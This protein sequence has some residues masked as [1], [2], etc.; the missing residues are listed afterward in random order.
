MSTGTDT[1]VPSAGWFAGR[2]TDRHGEDD[3]VA[4]LVDRARHGCHEAYRELVERHRDRVYRFCLG[5]TGN[6]EDAEELCQ[7]TFVRAYSALPR[8]SDED[9][10][11]AWLLRIARNR[12]HD[13]HR[14]RR[15]READLHQS[16]EARADETLVSPTL[17][18]DQSAADSDDL[19]RL[20]HAIAIL[21]APL[22]EVVVL[23][24]I[25]G[26]SHGDCAAL[27]GCSARAVE[28][29]LYRARLELAE[30]IGAASPTVSKT[31]Q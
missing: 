1:L 17:R 31:P 24:G 8:Y 16:L 30:R 9:R 25:E 2:P 7:D 27:L 14:S 13:H 18:P 19:A 23:C 12:C 3:P 15:R 21:P 5:W 29:R 6:P 28:G 22:R 11:T 20:R 4:G 26:M 10:F